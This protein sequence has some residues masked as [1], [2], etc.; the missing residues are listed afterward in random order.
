MTGPDIS[1]IIDDLLIMQQ[2]E[3]ESMIVNE[4]TILHELV[5]F[6]LVSESPA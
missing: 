4:G 1:G 6:V 3:T 5:R 2:Q